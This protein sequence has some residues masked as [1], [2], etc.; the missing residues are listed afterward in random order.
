[1]MMRVLSREERDSLTPD[2]IEFVYREMI[3]QFYPIDIIEKTLLQAMLISRID[4]SKIDS[5]GIAFLFERICECDD[6][7]IFESE[8]CDCDSTHNFC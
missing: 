2:A 6:A 8:R 1:M 5:E 4:Q 7:V 3:G